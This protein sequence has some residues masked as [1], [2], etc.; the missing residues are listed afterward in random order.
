MSS[1]QL[2]SGMKRGV[3]VFSL[4]IL[5]LCLSV[6][7]G[8]D[9]HGSSEMTK[10]EITGMLLEWCEKDQWMVTYMTRLIECR[11]EVN[12]SPNRNFF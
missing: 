12:V 3:V 2:T 8:L 1:Q 7:K 6:I 10:M 4:V 11:N 9:E 5:S